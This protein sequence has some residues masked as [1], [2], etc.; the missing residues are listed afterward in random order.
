MTRWTTTALMAREWN[1]QFLATI[2]ALDASEAFFE[3]ATFQKLL[4]GCMD[5]WSPE[6]VFRF[7]LLGVDSFEI[8]EILRDNLEKWRAFR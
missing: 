3:I 4:N 7:V 1:E 2:V 6:T 5:H 8:W